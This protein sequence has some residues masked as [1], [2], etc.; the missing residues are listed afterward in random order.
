M[1][2]LTF[3]AF[4][5]IARNKG[6]EIMFVC[7]CMFFFC[8][9]RPHSKNCL[10]QTGVQF[11]FLS[12]TSNRTEAQSDLAKRANREWRII[13]LS[14]CAKA[15]NSVVAE[16]TIMPLVSD[17]TYLLLVFLVLYAYLLLVHLFVY[18]GQN[19]ARCRAACKSHNNGLS[20]FAMSLWPRMG[21][22]CAYKQ[23]LIQ[24]GFALFFK[25][26]FDLYYNR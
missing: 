2:L 22:I 7:Y 16:I 18:K 14:E 4:P 17:S 3:N 12:P 19:L 13:C 11:D 6:L 21:R 1:C 9:T 20:R 24:F 10:R 26:T 25:Q 15:R 5:H 23:S 8:F